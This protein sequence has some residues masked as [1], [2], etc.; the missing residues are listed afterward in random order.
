MSLTDGQ[1]GG[2]PTD[3]F[4]TSAIDIWRNEY[5]ELLDAEGLIHPRYGSVAVRSEGKL[6][7][8]DTGAGP[9][10]GTLLTEM[11]SKGVDR[12]AVD[13]VVFTHLHGDHVG[14][15]LTDGRPTFPRARYLVPKEDWDYWTRPEVLRAS[16]AVRDQVVPLEGLAIL[17]LIE[18]E[19]RVTGELTTL[20]TPGHTPGHI[21]IVI[22][23]AGRRGFILGDV[24][25]SPAQARYTDWN[26][27]FDVDTSLSPKTRHAVF[28]RVESDGSLVSSGHFP[29]PGFGRLAR[30]D[31]RR[32]WQ[33]A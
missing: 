29:S 11:A 23:S 24:A 6:V 9:P 14:W 31:G 10:G 26:P 32:Y 4:P 22:T 18:G 2:L 25:H 5:P 1:G 27:S 7:V 19:Y 13:L 3:I 28:D 33:T 21:S 12:E 16:G 8:V 17:D 30:R 15:N 20:P